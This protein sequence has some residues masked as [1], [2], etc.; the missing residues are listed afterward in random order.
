MI[1]FFSFAGDG[2]DR[3]DIE[4]GKFFPPKPSPAAH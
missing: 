1:L 3:R 2:G 4:Q